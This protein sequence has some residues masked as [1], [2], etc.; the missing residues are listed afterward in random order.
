MVKPHLILQRAFAGSHEAM[1]VL[2]GPWD[3]SW[4]E[5][6]D[7][8]AG[9]TAPTGVPLGSVEYVSAY[10]R[11]A[12]VSLPKDF[13][14]P[15]CLMPYLCAE[16]MLR[17]YADVPEGCFV[18]PAFE[19]KAFTGGIKGKLVERVSPG[20]QVWCM[21]ATKLVAEWR[22]YVHRGAII[23]HA[24]YDSGDDESLE[25]NMDVA[26]RM[27]RDFEASGEA[28]VGYSVDIGLTHRGGTVLIEVND[29]WALGYYPWGT[30]PKKQYVEL[31]IDRW[32]QLS[33]AR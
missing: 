33:A 30:C 32:T 17:F 1:A 6:D 21:P 3:A 15:R 5:I 14:Y 19:I 13:S 24:R 4:S 26:T 10:A 27:V 9:L 2:S 31:L 18:K 7:I 12:G 28:P 25:F 8:E 23:G 22:L 29:G 20:A 16:P 11:C